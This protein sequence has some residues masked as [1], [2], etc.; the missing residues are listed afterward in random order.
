MVG[1]V[2]IHASQWGPLLPFESVDRIA[3][4]SV[5]AFMVL[6]GVLLAYQY[7]GRPLGLRFMRRRLS[8]SVLPWLVWVPVYVVFD[9]LTGA[10]SSNT[11]DVLSFLS[12]GAGHLWFL[13][14]IPQF[15]VLFAAWPRQRRWIIAGLAMLVQTALCLVRIYVALPGWQATVML[16]YAT[17]IF[18]FWIGYF[19]VGVAVGRSLRQPGRLRRAAGVWRGRLVVAATVAVAGSGFLLLRLP[20]PGAR[21]AD[22]FLHGTGAFLNPVLPLLVFS[23]A[24]WIALVLPPLMERVR[25]VGRAV[26][27]LS[28]QSLGVY[29]VHPILLFFVATYLVNAWLLQGGATAALGV[30]LIVVITLLGTLLVVRLLAATP[31]ATALGVPRRPLLIGREQRRQREAA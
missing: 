20:Y 9:V 2:C 31:V 25:A 13:L 6:T 29:I 8:R 1:V 7:S 14:L 23:A 10:L 12:L 4:F 15:Y 19:A 28:E 3:R 26:L 24:A 16:T 17:L 21:Y 27:L 30:T 18:P 5:P 22:S 11:S